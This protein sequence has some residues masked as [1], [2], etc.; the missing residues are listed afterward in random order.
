MTRSYLLGPVKVGQ[1]VHDPDG[2][3]EGEVNLPHQCLLLL[4]GER[5]CLSGVHILNLMRG[6]VLHVALNVR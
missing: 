5:Y 6:D 2:G 3:K 4:R 1:E